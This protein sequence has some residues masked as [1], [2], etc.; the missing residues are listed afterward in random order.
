[1]ALVPPASCFRATVAARWIGLT[2]LELEGCPTPAHGAATMHDPR[3]T[4]PPHS[5]PGRLLLIAA[6]LFP[7]P[8][9]AQSGLASVHEDFS[10]DPGWEG[11][12]NHVVATDNPTIRQDF[13]YRPGAIG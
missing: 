10:T 4:N 9:A 11:V 7:G 8:A 2:P 5:A 3:I 12:H 13:G 1:M 6:L